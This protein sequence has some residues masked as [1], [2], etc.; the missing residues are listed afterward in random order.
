MISSPDNHSKKT[1]VLYGEENI[2]NSILQFLSGEDRI[3]AC[4]DSNAPAFVLKVYKKLMENAKKEQGGIRLRFLTDIDSENINYCK[5]LMKFAEV[6]RHVEGIKANF[7]VRNTDYIGIATSNAEIQPSIQSHIIYSNVKGII[8]QQQYLFNSL[9]DK[10]VPAEQRIEE[11]ERGVPGRI[12][13]NH[14]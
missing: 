4:G 14:Q 8:Q 3:D 9:W 1:E 6:V 5:G 13:R 10:S 11:I 2:M 7:A 12:L